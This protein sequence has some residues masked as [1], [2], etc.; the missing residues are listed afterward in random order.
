MS[1]A[2][3]QALTVTVTDEVC[4]DDMTGMPYP[5]RVVVELEGR[6]LRGP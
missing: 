6:E 4:A 1:G 3:E 5:T 2:G